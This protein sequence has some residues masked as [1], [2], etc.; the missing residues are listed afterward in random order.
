MPEV[1]IYYIYCIELPTCKKHITSCM[2]KHLLLIL[3]T[4]CVLSAWAQPQGSLS[5]NG[6]FCN[7]GTGQ[8]IWTA[9]SGTGPFTVV[10]NDGTANHTATA[11][12]S[13]TPFNVFTNPVTTTTTYTLVSVTDATGVSVRTSGFTV[14][15]ATIT[16]GPAVIS[17]QG[18]Y[19]RGP[20]MPGR[21]LRRVRGYQAAHLVRAKPS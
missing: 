13:G 20:L 19:L 17:G 11:V 4:A 3:F 9:S 5:A 1:K 2:R 16:I 10:Y 15:S 12:A 18:P 7:S 8:L 6:P 14:G 21:F